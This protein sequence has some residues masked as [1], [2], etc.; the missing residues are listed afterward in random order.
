MITLEDI[1]RTKLPHLSPIQVKRLT[2]AENCCR[3]VMSN[4][5]KG[6]WFGVFEKLCEK[7]NCM[8]YF[9]GTIH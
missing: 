4:W 1:R 8:N 2:N 6:F 7:Y 3:N 9:R 5:A